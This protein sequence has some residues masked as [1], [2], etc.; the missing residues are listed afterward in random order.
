MLIILF[1]C[2]IISADICVDLLKAGSKL[3]DLGMYKTYANAQLVYHDIFWNIMYERIKLFG[4][5]FLLCFTPVRRYISLLAI[6]LFSFIW[7]FYTM[8]C[9]VE[10]GIAGVVVGIASVLPHG[11]LYGILLLILFGKNE[12]AIYQY[13]ERKRIVRRT[14]DIISMVLLLITGCVLESIVS[15][16]FIP[17][18]IRLSMI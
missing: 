1:I 17:W 18:V 10:L 8:T 2:G 6:C 14:F 3:L 16:H 11:I 15:T 5:V 7:G 9:I 13:Y 4:F 12:E